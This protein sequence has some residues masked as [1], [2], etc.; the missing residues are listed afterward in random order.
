M[1]DSSKMLGTWSILHR[2]Q[3]AQ[4]DGECPFLVAQL[5]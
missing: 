3:A 5:V 2:L 1:G 4:Q